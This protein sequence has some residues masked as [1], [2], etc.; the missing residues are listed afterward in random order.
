MIHATTKFQPEQRGEKLHGD[1]PARMT[2]RVN[3]TH[4]PA[5]SDSVAIGGTTAS[6]IVRFRGGSRHLL[7]REVVGFD[8]GDRGQELREREQLRHL[9]HRGLLRLDAQILHGSPPPRMPPPAAWAPAPRVASESGGEARGE[10]RG[11]GW[12]TERSRGRLVWC[13]FGPWWLKVSVGRKTEQVRCQCQIS[14]FFEELSLNKL[15]KKSTRRNCYVLLS[16][17]LSNSDKINSEKY[18]SSTYFVSQGVDYSTRYTIILMR[19]K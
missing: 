10:E 4:S 3:P 2:I 7:P 11:E 16:F 17:P 14:H 13:G 8:G 1:V 12:E 18:I 6:R 9:A 15:L 5:T 19:R